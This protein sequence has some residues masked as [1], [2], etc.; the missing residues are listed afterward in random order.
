[1]DEPPRITNT[2]VREWNEA[3]KD[4]RDQTT[5]LDGYSPQ[6]PAFLW[7]FCWEHLNT[8][9]IPIFPAELFFEKAIEIA[10]D[11]SVTTGKGFMRRFAHEI[12]KIENRWSIGFDIV[13][14]LLQ[15]RVFHHGQDTPYSPNQDAWKSVR[16]AY[17]D[18]SFYSFLDLLRGITAGW[19]PDSAI[20]SEENY[21]PGSYD[22]SEHDLYNGC[23]GYD[24]VL[25]EI[26][27]QPEVM[28]IP[29][30][31]YAILR[32]GSPSRYVLLDLLNS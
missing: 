9:R 3:I 14:H 5:P 16:N 19:K 11:E 22:P 30:N 31:D 23:Y 7:K 17:G 2:Q 10:K 8:M 29:P 27:T 18:R 12:P 25:D 20:E 32:K 13:H 26:I 28:E 4:W 6:H 21:V 15:K 1:M 24:Y